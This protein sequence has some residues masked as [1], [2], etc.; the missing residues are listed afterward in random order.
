MKIKEIT[1]S[2]DPK[3]DFKAIEGQKS[4]IPGISQPNTQ[5]IRNKKVKRKVEVL[6]SK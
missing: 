6:L 1:E 2:A 4:A 5:D 3:L